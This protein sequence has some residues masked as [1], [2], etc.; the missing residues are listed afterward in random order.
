MKTNSDMFDQFTTLVESVG[1]RQMDIMDGCSSFQIKAWLMYA[2]LSMKVEE[3]A[4]HMF[5]FIED[6]NREAAQLIFDA[7]NNI[8][9]N[10]LRGET[11]ESMMSKDDDLRPYIERMRKTML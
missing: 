2:V 4:Q 1:V 7:Q 8:L 5:P 11:I 3:I 6:P 10:I 9:T